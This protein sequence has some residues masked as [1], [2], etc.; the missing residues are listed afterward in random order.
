MTSAGP[1]APVGQ[2]LTVSCLPTK[3]ANLE[4]LE[5]KLT[6]W[7]HGCPL[8]QGDRAKGE[9]VHHQPPQ[10]GIQPRNQGTSLVPSFY[11]PTQHFAPPSMEAK[12]V[13]VD[14]NTTHSTGSGNASQPKLMMLAGSNKLH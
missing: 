3:V 8:R 6:V 5:G 13:P 2:L 9:G 12:G 1:D 10:A 14:P 11:T 4:A 7:R